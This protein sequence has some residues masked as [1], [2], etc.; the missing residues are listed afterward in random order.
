MEKVGR[1]RKRIG[2]LTVVR[3]GFVVALIGGI[4]VSVVTI[5]NRHV[6]KGNEIRRVEEGITALSQEIEMWE[7]RIARVKD[8]NELKRRLKW[9]GSSLKDI[10][11]NRVLRLH[12]EKG[13]LEIP[14]AAVF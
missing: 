2:L 12:S 6:L 14:V 8:R 4:G 5:R 10:E 3:L 13:N 11:M 1:Y 9:M 7:L